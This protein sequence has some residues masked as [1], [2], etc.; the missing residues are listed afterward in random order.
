MTEFAP[1]DIVEIRTPDGLAYVQLTHRHTSYPE[2]VRALPG[3][4]RTRPDDPAALAA[5]PARF[6]A[7]IPLRTAL[8]RLHLEAEVVAHMDIPEAERAFPTFRMPIRDKQG[9]VAYWWFW[10]GD[11]L[12]YDTELG[13][14]RERLPIR[15]VMSAERFIARLTEAEPAET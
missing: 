5:E 8:A 7:M 14:A 4:H 15:E 11:G 2:V 13:E 6:T 10:N 12:S 3:L 9:N 1:G